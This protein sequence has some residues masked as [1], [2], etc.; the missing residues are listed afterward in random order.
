MPL[1]GFGIASHVVGKRARVTPM[2]ILFDN[3]GLQVAVHLGQHPNPRAKAASGK[4]LVTFFSI[5][6]NLGCK[7]AFTERKV[8]P[9]TGDMLID[10]SVLVITTR[11]P[12]LPRR[13]KVELEEIQRFVQRGGSLLVMSNHP[14]PKMQNPIP[15]LYIA[16][17]FDVTLNGPIYP[18]HVRQGGL[19]EI[20]NGDLHMHPI[21]DGLNGPI[22][23]NDGCRI[24][25]NAGDILATLPGEESAPNVFAVAIDT[26]QKGKGRVVVTADSGFI[27]DDDTNFPGPGL[28]G[29][30]NNRRF[31]RQVF[32]WLLNRR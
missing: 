23:F 1:A 10:C 13:S 22:V 24:S 32:E 7:I 2:K 18:S 30:G 3:S 27:G 5:I 16:S 9:I 19:T 8:S 25:A 21:T 4:R 12:R 29:R 14:W 17:L 15:D 20:R 6:E 31:V 26:P 11:M 28:I